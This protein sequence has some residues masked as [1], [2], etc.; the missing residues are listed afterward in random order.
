VN[1]NRLTSPQL[2]EAASDTASQRLPMWPMSP[3][4]RRP[5]C[6]NR[7]SVK[8]I[9]NCSLR[10]RNVFSQCYDAIWIARC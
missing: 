1:R 2:V 8:K 10:P 4:L 9:E 3:E 6:A 7:R 5:L